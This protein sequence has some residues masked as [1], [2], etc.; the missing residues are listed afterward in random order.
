MFCVFELF[1]FQFALMNAAEILLEHCFHVTPVFFFSRVGLLHFLSI[2]SYI[3]LDFF[4]IY[5]F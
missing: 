5:L 1:H 2:R 3:L 4:A